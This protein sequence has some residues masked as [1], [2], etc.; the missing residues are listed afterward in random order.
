MGFGRFGR[1]VIGVGRDG[2]VRQ[3]DYLPI[4]EIR[5]AALQ[6]AEWPQHG[7]EQLPCTFPIDGGV[8]GELDAQPGFIDQQGTVA[9]VLFENKMFVGLCN[10]L[11]GDST[12]T[13]YT[14]IEQL[15]EAAR[16]G[17]KSQCHD[18]SFF[19][20]QAGM[21]F[22]A[23]EQVGPS[24]IDQ[25][26]AGSGSQFLNDFVRRILGRET[27]RNQGRMDMPNSTNSNFQRNRM[28]TYSC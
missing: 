11:S 27:E 1:F 8:G 22:H 12:D 16:L 13:F 24:P 21:I 2:S 17:S 14:A 28:V 26:I 7:L 10:T 20:D 25:D 19:A 18:L 4:D 6:L 9:A 15:P 3:A 5:V 23:S